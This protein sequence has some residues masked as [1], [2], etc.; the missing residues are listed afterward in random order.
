MIY[1]VTV[2]KFEERKPVGHTGE[3]TFDKWKEAKAYIDSPE[4]K[5]L[6]TDER[7]Q[8]I[9][10]KK[11]DTQENADRW[12]EYHGKPPVIIDKDGIFFDAGTGG[13][14]GTRVNVTNYNKERLPVAF[15]EDAE[16]D[17]TGLMK[18]NGT[19][20]FGELYALKLALQYALEHD[21]KKIY[22]D[23]KLVIF[24]WSMGRYNELRMTNMDT[25]HLIKETSAI[26]RK[27]FE[28]G[29]RVY[30]ISGD[31]NPADLGYHK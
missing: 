19:N 16:Y 11:F 15:P 7:A 2:I 9:R 14:K 10:Y 5:A 8:S 29:G 13:D 27:Y 3:K 6:I 20:N 30:Y 26:R 22:G 23:S 18:V 12:I 1:A 17:D 24:Y 28:G 4:L 21:I 31:K 25:I